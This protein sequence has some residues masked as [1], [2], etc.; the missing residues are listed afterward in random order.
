MR[1]IEHYARL[2]V[3]LRWLV[4]P[5]VG[6]ITWS[7]LTMLPGVESAGGGLASIAGAGEPVIQTQI[8]VARRFGLPLLTG[9]AVVQR[10]PHGLPPQAVENAVL[11][12]VEVRL[13]RASWNLR[14]RSPA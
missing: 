6:V 3:L 5:A 1:L 7:A 8:D 10:D 12:A 4:L 2:V 14:W 13:P 11:H 9:T